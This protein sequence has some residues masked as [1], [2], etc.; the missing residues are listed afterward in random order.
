[1]EIEMQQ[2]KTLY[3]LEN[4]K[5][6]QI[7]RIILLLDL[8]KLL[9]SSFVLVPR[10]WL[11]VF[12]DGIKCVCEFLIAC[13]YLPL[14]GK[15]TKYKLFKKVLKLFQ[16]LGL[17][18]PKT[19]KKTGKQAV[20]S[21]TNIWSNGDWESVHDQIIGKWMFHCLNCNKKWLFVVNVIFV[22]H[23]CG[24]TFI[25]LNYNFIW[26]NIIRNEINRFNKITLTKWMKRPNFDEKLFTL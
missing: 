22:F 13:V 21:M 12:S 23:N 7:L 25:C 1:M 19:K 15:Y 9:K 3:F 2:L 14:I 17:F 6:K 20:K 5:L 11:T 10:C 18:H 8:Q 4:T 16:I 24:Y 26:L